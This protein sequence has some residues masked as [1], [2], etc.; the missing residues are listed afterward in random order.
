MC[1]VSC[2]MMP[3]RQW[4]LWLQTL[5]LLAWVQGLPDVVKIGRHGETVS[6][7]H[8]VQAVSLMK[9]HSPSSRPLS[10]P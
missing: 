8:R 3:S 4:C 6:Q 7:G 5:V 10:G 2:A 9:T 1:W